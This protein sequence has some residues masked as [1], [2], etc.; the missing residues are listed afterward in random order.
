MTQ[1]TFNG[2]DEQIK[3]LLLLME[4]GDNDLPQKQNNLV[5]CKCGKSDH[6][7]TTDNAPLLHDNGID[8]EILADATCSYCGNEFKL[9]GYINWTVSK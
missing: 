9:I 1:I 5:C 6:I 7:S 4:H 2:T 3:N 8:T